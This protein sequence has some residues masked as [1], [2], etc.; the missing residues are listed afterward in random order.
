MDWR[1]A[2]S[3]ML[4]T[5]SAIAL[6]FCQSNQTH[7]FQRHI[8]HIANPIYWYEIICRR[9]VHSLSSF[10]KRARLFLTMH[11]DILPQPFFKAIL[12]CHALFHI[13]LITFKHGLIC[14][15]SHPV[16]H[17]L[18]VGSWQLLKLLQ[19]WCFMSIPAD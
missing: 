16:N 11:I 17:M 3:H 7:C 2:L 15:P 6:V 4:T 5:I 1:E 12:Y 19:P 8:H 9:L 10:K 13:T 14:G 18:S